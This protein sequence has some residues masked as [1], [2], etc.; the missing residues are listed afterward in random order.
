MSLTSTTDHSQANASGRRATCPRCHLPLSS[1]LC[2]WVVCTDNQWPVLVLQ[3]PSEAAHAKGSA[4]LLGLSLQRVRCVVVGSE[5][6]DALES[7]L[8]PP[9]HSLL[10]FP[11]EAPTPG[12]APRAEGGINL[13]PRP[14]QL[15]LLDG[16]WR[17]ARQ[18][19]RA[20]P[21]LQ[22]LPRLPLADPPP[23][24]YAIRRAQQPQHQRSTLEAACLALGQLEGRPGHYA[25]L[26]QA[27][28]GWVAEVAARARR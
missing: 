14:A 7:A 17:Q 19:L 21:R 12:S 23:S 10:L 26:L 13:A 16:T 18:M 9:G 4:R 11:A 15:V 25:P 8:G 28:S 27:F 2:R 5:G 6:D 3:H 24:R 22:A 1:C 20:S